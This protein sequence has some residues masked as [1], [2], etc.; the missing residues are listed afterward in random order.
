VRALVLADTHLRPGRSRS[1]P[2]EVEDELVRCDVVLHAGDVVTHHL[3]DHLGAHAPVHAVLGNND[4]E[5]R[6]VLPER[7]ELDLAGVRVVLVHETGA[8]KGRG[9]RLRRR[10]PDADVVVFCHSHIPVADEHDGLLLFNPGS[11]VDRRRQPQR[12]YGVLEL[13][14]GRVR[15]HQIVAVP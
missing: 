3:L 2:P 12:T 8:A 6:G 13:A 4:D 7:L 14:D 9:A 11:P 1:L 5:L 10:F 15:R